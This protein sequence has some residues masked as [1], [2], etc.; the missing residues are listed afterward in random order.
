MVTFQECLANGYGSHKVPILYSENVT[1]F[2]QKTVRSSDGKKKYFINVTKHGYL[3][4]AYFDLMLYHNENRYIEVKL[5]GSHFKTVTEV[6]E[7]IERLW[8]TMGF[9]INPHNN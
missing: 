7:Y 2:C 4:E 3:I 6:E 5:F 8:S 9:S 1:G